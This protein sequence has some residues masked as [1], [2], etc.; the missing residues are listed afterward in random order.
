MK[1]GI[2]TNIYKDKD[3]ILTKS[4]MA[5]LEARGVEFFVHSD[6]NIKN[7][8]TFTPSDRCNL[9]FM[10]TIGGDG[11]VLR[12]A[13]FCVEN[14]IPIIGINAGYKG[15]L[16]EVEKSDIESAVADLIDKKYSLER[17]SLLS[18]KF[19]GSEFFALND[20]VISRDFASRMLKIELYISDELV[21]KYYC[22]GFIVSTPTGST[23]YSLSAGGPVISPFADALSLTSIT[24]HSLHSRPI[25]ISG[26]EKVKLKIK[27]QDVS[28]KLVIDGMASAHIL[29]EGVVFAEM[30]GRKLSFV[31]LDKNKSGFYSKLLNKL[32]K[33]GYSDNEE[34]NV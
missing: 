30:S 16:N 5:A 6:I 32:N 15:F 13:R 31:R 10:F 23:A 12:I 21:D 26:D 2:Y 11:T 4:L 20:V 28:T 1:V 14:A 17:R 27:G 33:W 9:D 3:L 7:V 8:K 25:V 24:P 29:G 22:D 34:E 18:V 19:D